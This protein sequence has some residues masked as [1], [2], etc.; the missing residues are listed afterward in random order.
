MNRLFKGGPGSGPRPGAGG[1]AADEIEGTQAE[2]DKEVKSALAKVA[3]LKKEIAQKMAS[4]PSEKLKAIE[5]DYKTAAQKVSD[6]KQKIEESNA[7]IAA[8]KSQLKPGKK[9]TPANG[10][11]KTKVAKGNRLA[12][13]GSYAG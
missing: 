8:L 4:S 3:S 11:E 1:S 10:H 13:N 6:L 2:A 12:L 9:F 5:K 7:R